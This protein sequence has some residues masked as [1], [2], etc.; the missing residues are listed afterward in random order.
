[1]EEDHDASDFF[2][3]LLHDP[4]VKRRGAY[5]LGLWPSHHQWSEVYNEAFARTARPVHPRHGADFW[6]E[7]A[8]AIRQLEKRVVPALQ[9]ELAAVDEQIRR[10][11]LPRSLWK[12]QGEGMHVTGIWESMAF[13]DGEGSMCRGAKYNQ[14]PRKHFPESCHL[15]PRFEAFVKKRYKNDRIRSGGGSEGASKHAGGQVEDVDDFPFI[16]ETRLLRLNPGT[17]VIEHTSSTNQRIKIHCGITN[18]DRISM[19]IAEEPS[20]VWEEG[21]C[22][23]LEDSFGHSIVAGADVRPRVILQ[24]KI[25][26]PEFFAAMKAGRV[27]EE[28]GEPHTMGGE[29]EEEKDGERGR[30]K[31]QITLRGSGEGDNVSRWS[32]KAIYIRG[33]ASQY[34]HHRNATL[35]ASIGMMGGSSPSSVAGFTAAAFADLHYAPTACGGN[36]TRRDANDAGGKD[37]IPAKVFKGRT[38]GEIGSL[39][40]RMEFTCDVEDGLSSG[41]VG[42]HFHPSELRKMCRLDE[43]GEGAGRCRYF[44]WEPRFWPVSTGMLGLAQRRAEQIAQRGHDAPRVGKGMFIVLLRTVLRRVFLDVNVTSTSRLALAELLSSG[45]FSAIASAMP[46]AAA[47]GCGSFFRCIGGSLGEVPRVGLLLFSQESSALMSALARNVIR[48]LVR[49]EGKRLCSIELLSPEA[50]RGYGLDRMNVFKLLRSLLRTINSA[51]FPVAASVVAWSRALHEVHAESPDVFSDLRVLW[52]RVPQ[53]D[54][55]LRRVAF[56]GGKEKVLL[57]ELS[58]AEAEALAVSGAEET[59]LVW[60]RSSLKSESRRQQEAIIVHK[61]W[62][63]PRTYCGISPRPF[64]LRK[65]LCTRFTSTDGPPRKRRLTQQGGKLDLGKTEQGGEPDG[66]AGSQGGQPGKDGAGR[67]GKLDLTFFAIRAA[68]RICRDTHGAPSFCWILRGCARCAHCAFSRR[69]LRSSWGTPFQSVGGI[70]G[71]WSRSVARPADLI[72]YPHRLR[73]SVR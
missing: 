59:F 67:L 30:K 71:S 1:M 73:I 20:L 61:M 39:V 42:R 47:P 46:A 24:L 55:A 7:L 44:G 14:V 58:G 23:L 62:F 63:V 70:C 48:V 13:G 69:R 21:K 64:F 53:E 31:D 50:L 9:R 16:Q 18:P 17:R 60:R 33:G 37:I 19:K 27:I 4:Q 29:E 26:H 10:G 35:N 49:N 5:G 56:P 51:D 12:E 38:R 40:W 72:S 34:P 66:Q 15:L 32:I 11:S 3:L 36:Y 8:G 41:G 68:N 6:P 28:V 43:E 2:D 65:P 45:A 25:A 52:V 22:T 54:V 57:E